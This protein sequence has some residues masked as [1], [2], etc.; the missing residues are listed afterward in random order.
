MRM[1]RI[2]KFLF[3]LLTVDIYAQSG[4]QGDKNLPNLIPPSLDNYQF[5]K[6]GNIDIENNKGGF[7]YNIPLIDVLKY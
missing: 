5:V 1:N 2:F 7:N 6:Y 3:I 4:G